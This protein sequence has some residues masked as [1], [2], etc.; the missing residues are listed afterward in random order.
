MTNR[1]AIIEAFAALH[2]LAAKVD[3]NQQK[4][5]FIHYMPGRA[6]DAHHFQGFV[7][8]QRV[9]VMQMRKAFDEMTT[10]LST[11][12][13]SAITMEGFKAATQERA[14]A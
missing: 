4:V 13:L 10:G 8:A 11:E 5:N 14:A 3:A 9:R 2:T 1:T 12:E 7:D 6:D